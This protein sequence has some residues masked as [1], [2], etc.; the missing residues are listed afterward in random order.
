MCS[1]DALGDFSGLRAKTKSPGGSHWFIYIRMLYDLTALHRERRGLLNALHHNDAGRRKDGNSQVPFWIWEYVFLFF[2]CP[3][4]STSSR[5]KASR[6]HATFT[7]PFLVSGYKWHAMPRRSWGS[8]QFIMDQ[9]RNNVEIMAIKSETLS[10]ESLWSK[11]NR[12]NAC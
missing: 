11:T 12:T 8:Q 10:R 9:R 3:F 5:K 7:F 1:I 4:F 6:H 2:A